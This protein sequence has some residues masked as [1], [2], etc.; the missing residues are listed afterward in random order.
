MRRSIEKLKNSTKKLYLMDLQQT[1]Y[2][3][4]S[5]CT[6]ANYTVNIYRSFTRTNY[7]STSKACLSENQSFSS[8]ILTLFYNPNA[9]RRLQQK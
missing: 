5:K 9:T 8:N 2:L 7:V 3:T 6:F 4:I 1:L